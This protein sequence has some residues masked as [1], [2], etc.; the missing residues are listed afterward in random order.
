MQRRSLTVGGNSL[1][2]QNA[3]WESE[4]ETF[5]RQLL[6]TV[7]VASRVGAC[8]PW[9]WNVRWGV[10]MLDSIYYE[11]EDATWLGK[12]DTSGPAVI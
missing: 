8:V 2:K 7:E 1:K 6:E 11:C 10:M 4:L 9:R 3:G 5:V 12:V